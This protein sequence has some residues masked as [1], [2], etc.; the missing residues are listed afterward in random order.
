MSTNPRRGGLR[1]RRKDP[2]VQIDSRTVEDHRISF[3]ALGILAF[4]LNKPDGWDVRS[5]QIASHGKVGEDHDSEREGEAAVRTALR[6]LAAAGYYRLER[7]R[8]LDGKFVM[9][10]AISETPVAAWAEQYQIFRGA[11]AG[12]PLFEQQDGSFL[13]RYPDG[14]LHPEDFHEAPDTDSGISGQ[15]KPASGNPAS[16][17]PR[18]GLPATGEPTAG[19]GL[20]FKEGLP[21][22]GYTDSDHPSDDRPGANGEA[23]STGPRRTPRGKRVSTSKGRPAQPT[24]DGEVPEAEGRNPTTHDEAMGIARRWIDYRAANRTPVGGTHPLVKLGNLIKTYL[25][26]DYTD[27]E[28]R[29]ALT[30]CDT[31]IPSHREIE[32]AL[33][34]VR[35]ARQASQQRGQRRSTNRHIDTTTPE[36]RD[37][38]NPFRRAARSSD[39]ANPIV[40]GAA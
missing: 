21:Q 32:R 11:A 22:R 7:C 38:R 30:L 15:Q 4:L 18:S 8:L 33:A 39:V 23:G 27:I 20:P 19:E 2:F 36:E 17:A 26:V 1:K 28:I 34:E 29:H 35:G 12:V 3:R 14:S 37:A 25:E 10:T 9:S 16:G 24:L 40:E 6:E 13:L 31:G 5:T